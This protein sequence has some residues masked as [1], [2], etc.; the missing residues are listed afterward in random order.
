MLRDK[1]RLEK[2]I[3]FQYNQ[4]HIHK[5]NQNRITS[6]ESPPFTVNTWWQNDTQNLNFLNIDQK[7]IL[8]LGTCR[9]RRA[10][11]VCYQTRS[12][13]PESMWFVEKPPWPP[14]CL[15]S[16]DEPESTGRRRETADDGDRDRRIH[17]R[18]KWELLDWFDMGPY[19]CSIQ[20]SGL[21]GDRD[22]TVFNFF[23]L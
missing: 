16:W 15:C 7:R 9:A 3:I 4:I 11:Q 22:Q 10:N 23:Y 13:T 1:P 19:R 17:D 5:V 21:S 14:L 12:K 18:E 20:R 2:E 6:P 8:R